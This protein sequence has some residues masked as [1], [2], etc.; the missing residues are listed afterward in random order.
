VVGGGIAQV[1]D[2]LL[3]PARAVIRQR[4][5]PPQHRQAEVVQAALGDLSGL[6]GAAVMVFHD[7]RI[8]V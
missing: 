6:Y 4:A 2:L 7:L 5:F 1:G 3:E 8:N